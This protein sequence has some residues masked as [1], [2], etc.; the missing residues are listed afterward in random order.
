MLV[1]MVYKFDHPLADL[2][3]DLHIINHRDVL[4]IFA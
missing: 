3:R 2:G 1:Q 4:H